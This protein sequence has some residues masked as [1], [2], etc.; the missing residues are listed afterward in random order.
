MNAEQLQFLLQEMM[1]RVDHSLVSMQPIEA[2]FK[3]PTPS[4]RLLNKIGWL[5]KVSA[6]ITPELY[7]WM[8]TQPDKYV[9]K[10]IV[11]VEEI[12]E[13]PNPQPTQAKSKKVK[14]EKGEWGSFW[15]DMFLEGVIGRTDFKHLFDIP[16]GLTDWNKIVRGY[17]GLTDGSLTE[18]SPEKLIE[19]L[20]M[21][22][23]PSEVNPTT[24]GLIAKIK[25]VAGM[26][27]PALP[28]GKAF[29][30]AALRGN[31]PSKQE[32]TD[33]QFIKEHNMF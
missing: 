19:W 33:E 28:A 22:E 8:K 10:G 1:A 7:E 6:E 14:K 24:S 16:D 15:Q 9:L 26:G 29:S 23:H 2:E 30:P 12:G 18:V 5:R 27:Q 20:E 32:Q 3:D 11:W 21:A 13:T 4:E 25:E 31:A 17:F